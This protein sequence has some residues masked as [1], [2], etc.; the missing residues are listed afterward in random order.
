MQLLD[1]VKIAEKVVSDSEALGFTNTADSMRRVLRE[2]TR[3][4][5]AAQATL[6]KAYLQSLH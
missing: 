3:V 1:A 5:C 4:E 6:S 2:M